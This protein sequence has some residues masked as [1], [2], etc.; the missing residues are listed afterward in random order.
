MLAFGGERY[1]VYPALNLR[2]IVTRLLASMSASAICGNRLLKFL[3]FREDRFAPGF[4]ADGAV[5]V[6]LNLFCGARRYVARHIIFL[7]PKS[8][9]ELP[10]GVAMFGERVS[11][12]VAVEGEAG[13]DQ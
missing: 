13:E 4:D 1:R 5:A 12:P 2:R 9:P 11:L 8:G 3:W 6:Q 7:R 10:G